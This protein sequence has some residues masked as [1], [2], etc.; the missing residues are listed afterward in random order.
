[1]NKKTRRAIVRHSILTGIALDTV[2]YAF[3]SGYSKLDKLQW[4]DSSRLEFPKHRKGKDGVPSFNSDYLAFLLLNLCEESPIDKDDLGDFIADYPTLQSRFVEQC[5]RHKNA[6]DKE[7]SHVMSLALSLGYYAGAMDIEHTVLLMWADR[8]LSRLQL[9]P[10]NYH[11]GLILA[12][13]TFRLCSTG[14][15]GYASLKELKDH[16]LLHGE[17]G[18]VLRHFM[19]EHPSPKFLQNLDMTL[20]EPLSYF[21]QL[22]CGIM[23]V[24]LRIDSAYPKD[25][26]KSLPRDQIGDVFSFQGLKET[27]AGFLFGCLC[28]ISEHKHP[29]VPKPL[30]ES[31]QP[32][33]VIDS[34]LI[35]V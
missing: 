7:Y 12:Y 19:E 2:G 23:Y 33:G 9:D 20:F 27:D 8:F 1:M 11:T 24:L 30:R 28:T 17:I 10:I 21:E 26:L 15:F 34:S 31:V 14:Y 6:F 25:I 5:S 13:T 32:L 4:Y 29:L 22:L 3:E 16:Q 18:I 35:Y